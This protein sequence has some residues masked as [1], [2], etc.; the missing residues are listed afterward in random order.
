[1]LSNPSGSPTYVS[2]VQSR[3][4]CSPM[5]LTP[6]PIVTVSSDVQS[7][8]S[9]FPSVVTESGTWA[10]VKDMQPENA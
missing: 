10:D 7:A 4:M 5:D 3:N 2:A 1:M 8:N 9:D 6:F